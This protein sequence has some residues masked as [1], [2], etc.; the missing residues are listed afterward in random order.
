MEAWEGSLLRYWTS[1][2][3]RQ[4]P[5]GPDDSLFDVALYCLRVSTTIISILKMY[6]FLFNLISRFTKKGG[7]QF[8]GIFFLSI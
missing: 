3:E 5:Q 7:S 4:L 2:D 1:S 6:T 8:V